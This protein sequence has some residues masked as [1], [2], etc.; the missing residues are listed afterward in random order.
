MGASAL[1]GLLVSPAG[2]DLAANDARSFPAG[3]TSRPRRAREVGV[4]GTDSGQETDRTTSFSLNL[5]RVI[6]P[7]S[8]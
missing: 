1:R 5:S 2:N 4:L 6:Q 3:E 7:Q 8:Q